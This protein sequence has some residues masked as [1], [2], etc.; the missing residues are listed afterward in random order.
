MASSF[1]AQRKGDYIYD[2]TVTKE[3]TVRL[4]HRYRAHLSNA[5]RIEDGRLSQVQADITLTGRPCRKPYGHSMRALRRGG[6]RTHSKTKRE[7]R[8]NRMRC[9]AAPP[10]Q[11]VYRVMSETSNRFG[12]RRAS[13][14][15]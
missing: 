4:S 13:V 6:T 3:E 12:T 8:Q 9:R 7:P 10:S 14:G 15:A 1:Y 11:R 5:E 2:V